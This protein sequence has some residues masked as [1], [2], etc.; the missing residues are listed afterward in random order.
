ME[1]VAHNFTDEDLGPTK[2]FKVFY[3]GA[4][5]D[6]TIRA[7]TKELAMKKLKQ[8]LYYGHRDLLKVTFQE[9][10]E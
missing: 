5:T 7:P 10:A 2:D 6:I 9:I 4:E 8:Y 3:D 1:L